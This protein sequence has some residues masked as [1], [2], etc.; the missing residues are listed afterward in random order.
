MT[1]ILVLDKNAEKIEDYIFS[2]KF[3]ED[4]IENNK[5]LDIDK[6]K[7]F[8][9]PNDYSLTKKQLDEN[10]VTEWDKY[11]YILKP[12]EVNLDNWNKIKR[13]FYM[14]LVRRRVRPE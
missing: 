7:M 4:C 14:K 1:T 3:Q 11:D 2:I 13:E 5:Y 6:K 9:M 12:Q 10:N 8:S